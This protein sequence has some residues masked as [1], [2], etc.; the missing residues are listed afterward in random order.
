MMETSLR[1]LVRTLLAH[2]EW[3]LCHKRLNSD[4]AGMCVTIT[5]RAT[6][7]PGVPRNPVK[8]VPIQ[9]VREGKRNMMGY[10]NPMWQPPSF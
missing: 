6:C 1:Q 2:P 9:K 7:V 10:G 8:V 3:N 4:R 5:A